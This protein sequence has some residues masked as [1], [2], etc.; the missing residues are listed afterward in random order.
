MA[1]FLWQ[2]QKGGGNFVGEYQRVVRNFIG[3]YQMGEGNFIGEYQIGGRGI[4]LVSD[5]W[6]ELLFF[7]HYKL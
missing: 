2:Y 6:R 7:H 4:S 5:S 3:E 1:G